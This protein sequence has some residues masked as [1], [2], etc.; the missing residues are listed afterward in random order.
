MLKKILTLEFKNREIKIKFILIGVLFV[1]FY[2]PLKPTGSLFTAW[3][4]SITFFVYSFYLF[5][6]EKNK[7]NNS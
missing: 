5:F 6:L 4:G 3:L 1:S 7:S 2:F